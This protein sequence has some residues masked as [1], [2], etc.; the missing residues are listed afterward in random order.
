MEDPIDGKPALATIFRVPDSYWKVVFINPLS[1]ATTVADKLSFVIVAASAALVFFVLIG[2]LLVVNT[3]VVL[4]VSQLTHAVQQVQSGNLDAKVKITKRDEFGELANGFNTMTEQLGETQRQLQFALTRREAQTNRILETVNDGLCLIDRNYEIQ[5]Q[6]SAALED[7][8]ERKDL[9]GTNVLDLFQP[10]VSERVLRGTKD[11]IDILFADKVRQKLITSINPVTEVELAFPSASGDLR[12]K[13]LAFA[14]KRVREEGAVAFVMLTAQD[15]TA[16]V[17]LAKKLE[18]T[19]SSTREQVELVMKVIHVAPAALREFLEGMNSELTLVDEILKRP[20]TDTSGDKQGAFRRTLDDVFRR[21]HAIKGNAALLKL[22]FFEEAAHKIEERIVA[23]RTEGNLTGERFFPLVLDLSAMRKLLDQTTSLISRF[24]DVAET[25][26]GG[27]HRTSFA[28]ALL[29]ALGDF[30]VE[31]AQRHSKKVSFHSQGI[32][33][34]GIPFNAQ[35][36]L[37]DALVQFVRN[38]IIHGI[39]SPEERTAAGKPPTGRITLFGLNENG[40]RYLVLRDDGRG[41][42]VA[43]IR[44]RARELGITVADSEDDINLIFAPG[45]STRTEADL[46]AGRGIGLDMVRARVAEFGGTVSVRSELGKHTDFYVILSK[47]N[48]EEPTA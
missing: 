40:L 41:I 34:L 29:D 25:N 22:G 9:V 23:L 45:F 19:E 26:L 42:D 28:P 37:R 11:Y 3:G 5:P 7:I 33:E 24:R 21:L 43:K 18:A 48:Q 35:K 31:E 2:A 27:D 39:E 12:V 36:P 20:Q 16:R 46:S 1:A 17:A 4:P 13:K 30:A 8:M 47:S 14:F 10:L 44:T 38:A 15:I 6:Y 32:P